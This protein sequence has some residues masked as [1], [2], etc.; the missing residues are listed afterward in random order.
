MTAPDA[1]FADRVAAAA[2][3]GYTGIGLRPKHRNQALQQGRSDAD[4]RAIMAEHGVVLAEL[5]VLSGWG[6]DDESR[7]KAS[8]HEQEI[9]ELAD[10]L[11]GRHLTVTGAGLE[12]PIELIAE[13]FAGVCDR[14]AEHDVK[15]A[16]E[17]LPWTEVPD[18]DAAREIVQLAGRPNAGIQ[19]DSWHHF[20]GAADDEQLR[21]LPPELVMAVQFDDDLFTG[22]GT[23]YE[24]TFE[25]LVPGEGEFPL[26]HF[27]QVLAEIGVTA[28]IGVEVISTRLKNMPVAEAAQ[29]TA[30]A[31]FAI[32]DEA[33]P[34]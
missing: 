29:I 30:D 32:L 31:T 20:R 9:W 25:R 24:Q 27:L 18:A 1:E 7:A 19:V 6:G 26:V 11:G 33:F 3:A 4:L 12:G 10:A 23:L 28:P 14:A 8:R 22:E 34:A 17:F 21:R 15:I 2:A 13:R 5:E 16:L